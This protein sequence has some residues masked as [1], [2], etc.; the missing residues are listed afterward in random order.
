M[1]LALLFLLVIATL[2]ATGNTLAVEHTEGKITSSD[3]LLQ[4][5]AISNPDTTQTRRLRTP[6]SPNDGEE[7]RLVNVDLAIKD[8]VHEVRKL[9]KW[10]LQ[11][12]VWKGLKK[13]PT[14]LIQEWGMKYPYTSDPR[15]IVPN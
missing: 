12:A 3:T 13:S 1:R 6:E 14:K 10:K 9:T 5:T 11:F 4:P 8:A 15:N 2:V 7:R